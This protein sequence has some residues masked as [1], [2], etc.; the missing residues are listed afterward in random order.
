M[1]LKKIEETEKYETKKI[2]MWKKHP[3]AVRQYINYLAVIFNKMV[4]KYPKI[5]LLEVKI[6]KYIRKV[7][8]KYVKLILSSKLRF[9]FIIETLFKL[10]K[11]AE[12]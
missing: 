6:D 10:Q 1:I 12:I 8:N 9:R 5:N 2:N 4:A 7:S 11:T 3:H